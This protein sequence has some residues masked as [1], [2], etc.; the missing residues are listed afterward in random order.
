MRRLTGLDARADREGWLVAYPDGTR[1][2]WNDGR[3]APGIAAQAHGVDDVGFAADLVAHLVATAGADPERVYATG[4]SNGAMFCHRLAAERPD[5]VAAIAP[6]AG[7]LPEPLLRA[8][9]PAAPVPVIMVH[10]TVDPIVP[11]NGGLVLDD[12]GSGRVASVDETVG[13]WRKANRTRPAATVEHLPHRRG[14][15]PTTVRVTTWPAGPGGA[16]VTLVTVIAGGHTWPGG[17]QYLPPRVIGLTAGDVAASD[18]IVAF[19]AGR[20]GTT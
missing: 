2:H 16:D 9:P 17:L 14:P 6:V 5:L 3:G 15:D 12:A 1:G 10:G 4:M 13:W 20:S 18:L 19:L 11:W 8:P 7:L